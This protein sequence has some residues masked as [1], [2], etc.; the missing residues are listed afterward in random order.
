MCFE[1]LIAGVWL[2]MKLLVEIE[3]KIAFKLFKRF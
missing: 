1:E 2:N 3:F